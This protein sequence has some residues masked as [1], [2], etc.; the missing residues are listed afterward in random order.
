MENHTSYW[1][2]EIA[3]D[4]QTKQLRTNII[5]NLLI[6]ILRSNGVTASTEIILF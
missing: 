6:N 5:I 4:L 3:G 1:V 2:F